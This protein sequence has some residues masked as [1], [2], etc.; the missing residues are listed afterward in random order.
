MPCNCCEIT[1]HAFGEADA[2]DDIRSYRRRGPAG[3]TREILR[4]IRAS[5]LRGAALLDI[6]GGVGVI[7]HELLEDAAAQA[8]HVDAS[9]AYLKQAE[10]EASRRGHRE[11]VKFMHA[12]FTDVAAQLPPADIV[13]LDRVVCCYPDF[14]A[15]LTAAAG[16]SRQLLAMSYP[17][18]T[19]YTRIA[20]RLIDFFQSLR[21]DPFRVFLHPRAD[22]DALL[23]N[24]GMERVSLKRLFVWEIALY[25]RDAA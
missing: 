25:A 12:D 7:H 19:W 17:R 8:T 13:T 16:H 10:E 11:R 6:G 1:D 18:E 20:W 23:R 21:R 9:A 22:M 2:R 15:L 3:Q 24:A 4:A 5:G 14:R